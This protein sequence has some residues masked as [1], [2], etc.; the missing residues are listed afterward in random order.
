[1]AGIFLG[2]GGLFGVDLGFFASVGAG[3][4]GVFCFTVSGEAFGCSFWEMV[5]AGSTG[6]CGAGVGFCVG[7]GVGYAGEGM[8]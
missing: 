8:G 6:D 5:G 7:A 3:V 2:A 4:S 1:M